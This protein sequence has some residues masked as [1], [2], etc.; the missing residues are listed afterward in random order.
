MLHRSGLRRGKTFTR[1]E[2]DPHAQSPLGIAAIL[3]S[4]RGRKGATKRPKR[5]RRIDEGPASGQDERERGTDRRS[6]PNTRNTRRSQKERQAT[7]PASKRAQKIATDDR[8]RFS[9][10][11]T[12]ATQSRPTSRG[13]YSRD[14]ALETQFRSIPT[15]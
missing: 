14:G 11:Y 9:A 3:M 6:R 15:I 4:N 8:R 12:R 1:V 10:L 13:A 5:R 2:D 7:A